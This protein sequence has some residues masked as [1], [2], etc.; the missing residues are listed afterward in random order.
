MVFWAAGRQVEGKNI[1]RERLFDV[2]EQ[3]FAVVM[4]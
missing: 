3:Y 1:K 4:G 2:E